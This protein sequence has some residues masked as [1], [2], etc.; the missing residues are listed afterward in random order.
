M[1]YQ[2][3]NFNWQKVYEKKGLSKSIAYNAIVLQE[4]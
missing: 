4:R 2:F 1:L 3:N